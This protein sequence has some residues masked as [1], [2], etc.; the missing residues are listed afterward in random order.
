MF[1]TSPIFRTSMSFILHI[2]TVTDVC[3]VSLGRSGAL[4]KEINAP[5]ARQH[6]S[7]LSV[8]IDELLHD[9]QISYK[10]LAAI[11][12]STG[13]GSYTGLRV[14]YA[15]TKGLCLSLNIPMIKVDTLYSLAWA[16]RAQ[17]DD[18]IDLFIPMVDARRM[19]VYSARYDGQLQVVQPVHAWILNEEN[20]DYLIS[21]GKHIAF[22]GNGAF[23]L[24]QIRPEINH[25]DHLYIHEIQCNA[26]FLIEAA[27][28]DYLSGQFADLAYSTPTYLKPPNITKPKASKGFI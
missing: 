10:D 6:I 9:E 26:S 25:L 7:L 21:S 12:V 1:W 11:A 23:K 8:L 28:N 13:P 16:M 22:G 24:P 27:W 14:G 20:V 2:E 5:E 19:E 15:T 4:I 17:H 18:N 3:S